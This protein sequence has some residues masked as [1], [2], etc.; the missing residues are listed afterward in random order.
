[1]PKPDNLSEIMNAYLEDREDDLLD[2]V[3]TCA[4][5]IARADGW[6]DPVERQQLLDFLERNEFLL[7]FT[8]EQVRDSFERRVRDLREPGG[9][10]AALARIRRHAGCASAR[11]VVAVGEEVAS[12]DCRIDPRE[13]RALQLI[14]ASLEA[15]PAPRASTRARAEKSQ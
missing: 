7:L 15:R 1:M 3:V 9:A 2:A 13:Q 5:L 4:A 14:R 11:M 12:A 6:V 8:N 10:V